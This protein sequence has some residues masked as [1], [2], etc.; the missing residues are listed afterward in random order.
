MKSRG[1]KE[2]RTLAVVAMGV[3]ITSVLAAQNVTTIAGGYVG[4]G[5]AATQ[6]A[7][8]YPHHI[9]KDRAGNLYI[10]EFEGHRIRKVTPGGVI[11]TYAGTGFSGYSGDGGP[12]TKAQ[13]FYPAGI[14]FDANGNL[15]FADGGSSTVR[16]ITRAGIISTIAG[17][18]VFGYSG[19]GGPAIQA[20]LG[21]PWSVIYDKNGNLLIGDIGDNVV[22]KVDSAGIITTYAGNGTVGY[23]GDGGPAT[24]A[25]MDGTSGL[26]LDPANNLYIADR[27]NHVVRR[28]LA[29]TGIISTFAGN[30][31][32]GYSGDG[33]QA[34]LA[35]IGNPRG[36]SYSSGTLYISNGGRATLRSVAISTQTIS[37]Y[38]GS[39]F[40]YDGDGNPLLSSEFSTPTGML[41]GGNNSFEIGDMGNMRVRALESGVLQTIA[42][43]YIGDGGVANSAALVVPFA[44]AF[45]RGGNYYTADANGNR[46]RRVTAAG[47]ITTIAGNGISGYSGDGGSAKQ[48]ELYNPEGVAVDTSGNVFISDNFNGVIRKV[49]AGKITTFASDPNMVSPGLMATDGGNNLY[50]VDQTTCVLWKISP[51]GAVSVAAGIEF[52]CGYNGD[53][54]SAT[55]A[56]LNVPWGVAI[57]TSGNIYIAD[58]ANNRVRKIN[59][60]GI[61]ITFA[62]DGNCGFIDNVPPASAEVCNPVAVAVSPSGGAVYIV[63]EFNLRIRKVASN[64][65][66]TFAGSGLSGFNGD[67]PALTTNL[68]DPIAIAVDRQGVLYM[69][70]D[71]T[72]RIRK[73]H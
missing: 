15:I 14:T 48:A 32:P 4:D 2:A 62:G 38:A 12:A 41:F 64:L 58:S 33:G 42:G 3:L 6:A 72:N 69:V 37:T 52:S 16:K 53:H 66:T 44:I 56:E 50:V 30:G 17:N 7:L 25:T 61:I 19:D 31:Q 67:G 55:A 43:G 59:A 20:N 35:S 24:Q 5:G 70:D 8:Y 10:T 40:G 71:A 60:S 1:Q 65:I 11:S 51:A 13:L 54:I 73:I 46:V 23:S 21:Q 27:F 63:D 47:N 26:A 22:R 9:A 34:T 45:D 57:D 49:S 29:S 18:G 68:E 39:F 28:V 36:L